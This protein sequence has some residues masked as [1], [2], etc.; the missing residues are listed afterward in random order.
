VSRARASLPPHWGPGNTARPCRCGA[1]QRGERA[2]GGGDA[3]GRPWGPSRQRNCVDVPSTVRS[4]VRNILGLNDLR[5]TRGLKG[6]ELV[7]GVRDTQE[8]DSIKPE[9]GGN[10]IPIPTN[11][12][13][14]GVAPPPQRPKNWAPKKKV[15]D[16]GDLCVEG[17][18]CLRNGTGGKGPQPQ[19]R[20]VYSVATNPWGT[21]RRLDDTIGK[22]QDSGTDGARDL[23]STLAPAR[24]R[25]P[26]GVYLHLHPHLAGRGAG[27][28]EG[29]VS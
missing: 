4:T 20:G 15:H 12:Q 24:P 14:G 11:P 8:Q 16:G 13:L 17:F 10:P 23:W 21:R 22:R 1:T 19:G 26:D 5:F 3:M 28:G 29:S 9:E 25:P 7:A 27:G 2:S 18:P 6:W